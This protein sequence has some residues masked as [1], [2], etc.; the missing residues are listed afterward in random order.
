MALLSACGG[1]GAVM[2][3]VAEDPV[4][5]A[6]PLQTPSVRLVSPP[7]WAAGDVV[8][9]LGAGFVDSGRGHTEL[10]LDG[11]F[12]TAAGL[13]SPVSM[14]VS[15]TT[16]RN[17]GRV[18]FVFEPALPPAG[19]GHDLGTFT[20]SVRAKNVDDESASPASAPVTA[21]I[22][23]GPS[24]ILWSLLPTGLA[25]G[26]VMRV[27]EVQ[28][29]SKIDV[30]L[31][32]VGLSTPTTTAPLVV[33]A[34]FVDLA[35]APIEVQKTIGSGRRTALTLDVGRL[36]DGKVEA[37]LHV[38]LSVTDAVGAGVDRTFSVAVGREHSVAYDGN[39]RVAEL[40]A[41]VQVSSC[42]PGGA[43]G[44]DVSYSSGTSESR[45]RTIGFSVDV[46]LN[47]WVVNVGFG[48]NVSDSVSTTECQDLSLNGHINPG[49]FGVFYRQ[50]QRLERLG[51]IVRL[52]S[53][54]AKRVIGDARVTDWS[55]AP[56][57]AITT[58]RQCPPAPPSNLPP[59]QVF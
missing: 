45:S 23:V 16:F 54:G 46:G 32:A 43:T 10:A 20:G 55:W 4:V 52:D 56:D 7:Q 3:S 49:Q 9:V 58:N 12:V 5:A 6:E 57:L 34:T 2:S 51:Q 59:A 28:D 27:R 19:F 21:A 14:T 39:V 37:T 25:C 11:E 36:P 13:R 22:E 26:E 35:N 47:I 33:T 17:A 29:G 1:A 38:N 53:C 8:T 18:E 40:Y 48:I 42:L 30:N 50:T 24:L 41:P 44:R 31:E 15:E